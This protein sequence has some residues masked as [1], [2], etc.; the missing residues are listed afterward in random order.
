MANVSFSHGEMK[1]FIADKFQLSKKTA[2]EVIKAI[3]EKAVEE[4][5]E[6]KTVA[7]HGLG[8]VKKQDRAE[9][10]ARNPQTGEP[11]TIPA[12]SIIKVAISKKVKDQV[13]GI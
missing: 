6:G 10:V 9:R 12:H 11:I 5:T 3:F 4:A 13:K 7:L 2:D 1:D 8:S